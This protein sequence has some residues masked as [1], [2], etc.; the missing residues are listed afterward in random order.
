MCSVPSAVAARSGASASVHTDTGSAVSGAIT[1]KSSKSDS[2]DELKICISEFG[3]DHPPVN[4]MTVAI[5]VG[6][7][8]VDIVAIVGVVVVAVVAIVG[9]VTVV[10]GVVV[11]GG[12]GTDVVLPSSASDM[13]MSLVAAVPRL[14]LLARVTAAAAAAVS[15]LLSSDSALT[16]SPPSPGNGSSE[17]RVL[18][19][20]SSTIL[21]SG[22]PRVSSTSASAGL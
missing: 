8:V 9:V 14:P 21:M 3:S 7:G 22:A 16:L 5:V 12:F 1:R 19:A 20:T 11:D 17:L 15:A 10:G 4:V 18:A 13:S 2:S 6:V